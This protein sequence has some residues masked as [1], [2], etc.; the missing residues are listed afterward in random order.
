MRRAKVLRMKKRSNGYLSVSLSREGMITDQ[1]V[2]RLV[3]RTFLGE[4]TA[5]DRYV[6]HKNLVKTDNRASNLEWCSPEYNNRH[7]RLNQEYKPS[8]LRKRIRCVEKNL[9]FDSS[10]QAA[11][12]VNE[13]EK[14]FSGNV[15]SMARR[16][17]ASAS[18]ATQSAYG[19][20]W[21]DEPSTTIPKGSTPKRVEMGD[22]S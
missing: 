10:Y 1:L 22:P 16:I 14:Q 7:S 13:V 4:P 9:V 21:I 3:A 11:E 15:P 8:P 20:K 2:H 17:R 12:W 19:Y 18:G 5:C 6:N